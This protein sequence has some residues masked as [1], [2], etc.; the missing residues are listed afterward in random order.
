MSEKRRQKDHVHVRAE[1][2]WLK[3]SME[4]QPRRAMNVDE[5]KLGSEL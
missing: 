2:R 3:A 1:D 4:L 5:E